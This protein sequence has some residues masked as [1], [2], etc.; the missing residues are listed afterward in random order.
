MNIFSIETS[1]E[2][3]P[4]Y[5]RVG[6]F[7]LFVGRRRPTTSTTYVFRARATFVPPETAVPPRRAVRY[8]Y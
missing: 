7:S 2:Q 6:T 5:I 3:R 8:D 4:L 1:S